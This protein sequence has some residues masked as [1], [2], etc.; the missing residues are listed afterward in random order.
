M[1]EARKHRRLAKELFARLGNKL[2]R[3]SSVMFHFLDGAQ[4]SLQTRIVCKVNT[5][6]ATLSD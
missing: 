5:A 2:G 6:S 1:V 3:E 4:P